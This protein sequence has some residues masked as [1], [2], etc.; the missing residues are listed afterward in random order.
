MLCSPS[1][2][3]SISR[4]LGC[5]AR[6][7]RRYS[8]SSTIWS[9]SGRRR[10]NRETRPLRS[11]GK[12]RGRGVLHTS[13][14]RS[15][16]CSYTVESEFAETIFVFIHSRKHRRCAYS[17]VPLHLHGL[18]NGFSFVAPPTFRQILHCCS[19]GCSAGFFGIRFK[20]VTVAVLGLV[21]LPQLS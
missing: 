20:L 2:A 3:L 12:E 1:S 8:I 14:I 4:K 19:S 5:L 15:A 16:H 11:R 21:K 13:Q 6:P 9:S 18:T 10:S 17:T 7:L